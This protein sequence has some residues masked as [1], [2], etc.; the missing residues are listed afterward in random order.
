MDRYAEMQTF[1]KV[2]ESGSIS[3]TA[4]R[5]NIAKSAVSRRLADLETRLGAQL[6]H[7]TTRRISLTDAGRA[8][9]QQAQRLLAELEEV[10]Q[11]VAHQQTDLRGVLRVAAPLSFGIKHLS[12]LLIQF[13]AEHPA[14]QL[15]LN[16]DDRTVNLLEE[17]VDLAIRIGHLADSS[18]IARRLARV[19]NIVCASPAYLAQYGE[20]HTPGELKNHQVLSYSHVPDSLQWQ[21]Q[22]APD[23]LLNVRPPVKMRANNGDVLLQAAIAGLGICISPDFICDDAL[24]SGLLKPILQQYPQPNIAIYAVYP[25][26]RHLPRRVR[27]LIDFLAERLKNV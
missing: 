6:L 14:L 21:F 1:V 23:K 24:N 22:L 17:G 12:P 19:Q 2:A 5:L 16:L 10:E 18:L 27:V 26:Q 3:A 9:F 13:M 7:R 8:Y 25:A 4:E 11:S 15:E 20:P